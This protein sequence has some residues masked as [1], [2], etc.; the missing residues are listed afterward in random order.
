MAFRCAIEITILI[1]LGARRG[2]HNLL[3]YACHVQ[4]NKVYAAINRQ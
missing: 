2:A 3:A 1:Y 4:Y